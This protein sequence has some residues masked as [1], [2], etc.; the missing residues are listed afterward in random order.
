MFK[1]SLF[2]NQPFTNIHSLHSNPREFERF[3]FNPT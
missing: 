3:F 2:K 1:K